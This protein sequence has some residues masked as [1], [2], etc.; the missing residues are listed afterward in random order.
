MVAAAVA[1]CVLPAG[2]GRG[3]Q[4]VDGGAVQEP[5]QRTI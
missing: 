2:I 4:W 1:R 3:L 5:P